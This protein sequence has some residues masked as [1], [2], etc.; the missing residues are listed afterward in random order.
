MQLIG[1]VL[2]VIGL[3][4]LY[5]A[6]PLTLLPLAAVAALFVAALPVW[7]AGSLRMNGR[8]RR[9]VD[10]AVTREGRV[11]FDVTWE[12][13][14]WPVLP[15]AAAITGGLGVFALRFHSVAGEM[16]GSPF[17]WYLTLATAIGIIA[18]VP[19]C[20]AFLFQDW[21]G[22]L[23]AALTGLYLNVKFA[24]SASLL[25]AIV[26]AEGRLL[27]QLET[28]GVHA[29]VGA[30]ESCREFLLDHVPGRNTRIR[31]E[32]ADH[33]RML[34]AS[35][36]ALQQCVARRSDVLAAFE[37]AKAA[38]IVQGGPTLLAELDRIRHGL[39]SGNLRDLFAAGEWDE[40]P[41]VFDLMIAE[42]DAIR[43]AAVR[44]E[45]MSPAAAFTRD[46][47]DMA[48][49]IP[50]SLDDAY[51]VLNVRSGATMQAIKR[52]VDAQR[53]NWHPDLASDPD[54]K[55]RC[56]ARIQCINAAWDI[57]RAQHAAS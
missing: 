55:A 25:A 46:D 39:E 49:Q 29:S 1:L 34:E 32:L 43:E 37:R 41:E 3:I 15:V 53:I 7:I 50:R 54:E 36:G 18:L 13:P 30:A 51:R 4:A 23:A 33:L 22:W 11:R 21:L 19:A 9:G 10:L 31:S 12:D 57:I 17:F 24:G 5:W 40:I 35:L 14:V 28:V 38:V 8:F 6:V 52:V 16:P 44:G 45:T 26:A 42:L 47:F 2:M 27:N 20:A 56:T 48:G